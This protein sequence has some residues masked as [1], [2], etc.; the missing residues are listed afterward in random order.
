VKENNYAITSQ[1]G[2]IERANN[3]VKSVNKLI[4]RRRECKLK[5]SLFSQE[6]RQVETRTDV[7]PKQFD[8]LTVFI[9]LPM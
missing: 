3:S 1:F 6:R 2:Q 5:V 8:C 9:A 7:F 4:T